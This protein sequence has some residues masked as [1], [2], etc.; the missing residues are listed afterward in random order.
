VQLVETRCGK[1]YGVRM[2]GVHWRRAHGGALKSL[3]ALMLV[4]Q[5]QEGNIWPYVR[6][7]QISSPKTDRS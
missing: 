3:V 2:L 7:K 6:T 1:K 5:D 4:V